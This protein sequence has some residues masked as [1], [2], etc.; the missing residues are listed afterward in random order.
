[1]IL[2]IQMPDPSAWVRD[3]VLRAG[4]VRDATARVSCKCSCARRHTYA[5]SGLMACISNIYVDETMVCGASSVYDVFFLVVNEESIVYDITKYSALQPSGAMRCTT[6]VDPHCV[7][8]VRIMHILLD[9]KKYIYI[10]IM[11]W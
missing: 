9:R 7:A 5:Q 1:M 2:P 6:S 8:N 4:V 11:H 10:Y 3:S